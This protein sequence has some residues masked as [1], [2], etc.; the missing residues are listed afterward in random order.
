MKY[1]IPILIL[2][3]SCYTKK[4]AIRNFCSQKTVGIDTVL[5]Y[6]KEIIP[7]KDSISVQILTDTIIK[8]GNFE[9]RYLKGDLKVIYTPDT[10]FVRDSIPFKVEVPVNCPE[11]DKN[12]LPLMVF[13]GILLLGLIAFFIKRNND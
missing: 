7:G 5:I 8:E 9:I 6:E 10:I 1:L 13:V 2:L 12:K 3:S 4:Q 11:R